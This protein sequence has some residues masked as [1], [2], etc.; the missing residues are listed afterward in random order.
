MLMVERPSRPLTRSVSDHGWAHF[1][2]GHNAEAADRGFASGAEVATEE[3]KL[4]L[5]AGGVGHEFFRM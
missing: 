1:R 5:A 4:L 2:F 3:L